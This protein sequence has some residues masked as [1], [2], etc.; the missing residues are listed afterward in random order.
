MDCSIASLGKVGD[1]WVLAGGIEEKWP[2][3]PE[4]RKPIH[5]PRL[6]RILHVW[7]RDRDRRGEIEYLRSPRPSA[8]T[9]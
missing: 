8:G 9:Q 6:G 1:L 3:C 2:T 5:E 7:L 4:D